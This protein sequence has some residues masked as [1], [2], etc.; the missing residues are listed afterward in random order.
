MHRLIT[1]ICVLSLSLPLLSQTSVVQHSEQR[2]GV[3]FRIPGV[4]EERMTIG[5]REFTRLSYPGNRYVIMHGAPLIPYTVE[6]VAIPPDARAAVQFQINEQEEIGP[7]DVLPAAILSGREYDE[8][9]TLNDSIY[10]ADAAFPGPIV[11]LSEPYVYRNMQVVDLRIYPVQFYALQKRVRIFKRISIQINI[12]GGGGLRGAG[13]FSKTERD[14]LQRRLL[15]FE[16]AQG[17]A[18]PQVSR[19]QRITADYDFSSGDWYRIPVSAEG[20]YR[21]TGSFLSSQGISISNVAVDQ[22]QMF[23]HGGAPLPYRSSTPVPEDLNEIAI[24]VQDNNNNGVLDPDDVIYFYG[25]GVDGWQINPGSGYRWEH[26]HHPYATRNYYLLTFNHNNGKRIPREN[27]IQ[28]ANPVAPSSFSDHFHFEEDRYNLLQSGLDWYWIRLSG[29]TD[30]ASINFTLPQNIAAEEASIRVRLKNGSSLFY[31]NQ[32]DVYIDSVNIFINNQNVGNTITIQ[33]TSTADREFVL[34]DP[35]I[36]KA[37][38]NELLIT[39]RGSETGAQTYLDFFEIKLKRPFQAENSFLKINDVLD[40]NPTEYGVANM[41]ASGNRVWDVTDFANIKEILPLQNSSTVVFQVQDSAQTAKEYYVF[42]NS[43]AKTVQQLEAIENTP[44]L[45]DP[46]RKGKLIIIVPDEFYDAAEP[47]ETLRE[48][49]L[50]DP[51]ETER[52]K[53]SEI[54]REFSSTVPDPTAIRNFLKYAY[55]NWRSS[56]TAY[57]EFVMLLGDGSYDYKNIELKNYINRVPTFQITGSQELTSRESDHYYVALTSISFDS[58]LPHLAIGR[59]PVNSIGELETFIEKL[60]NY[61]HSY[62]LNPEE[63]GWQNT[64]TFVADDEVPKNEWIHLGD[65][66]SLVSNYVPPRF[67]LKKIYLVEYP[68]QPGGFGRIKPQATEE[69]INQVNRGTLMINYFGHGNPEA[70]AHEQVFIRTR[71][72]SRIDN[73]G[74]LP[75]W[76]AATCDWA[77]FDNPSRNSMAEEMLWLKNKGGIGVVAATRPVYAGPN[78]AFVKRFYGSLFSYKSDS[79]SKITGYSMLDASLASVNDQKFR[80]FGDPSMKLADAEHKVQITSITPDT[81][82]ALSTIEVKAEVRG[83]DNSLISDF[84][85][86][87]IV[88]VFD[89]KDTVT[90]SNPVIAYYT[91]QEKGI[92]KGLISVTNGELTGKFIVPKSIKY[93]GAPNGRISI[94]AWSENRG[95]AA[96]YRDD[97]LIT[98]TESLTDNQGPEM[99][100]RF[101]G[102]EDFFDGDYVSTQPT[103]IVRL[104]DESGINLT[105][106][107]GHRIELTIDD[108][109]KKDLTDFF[110]YEKDSY[111]SGQLRYTLPALSP[112]NHTVKISAWDNVNNLAEREVNFRTIQV[113]ELALEDVVNYPNPFNDD[114]HFTFQFQSPTGFAEVTIKIYTVTGRLI[115]EIETVARPGFNKVYWDGRDRDGDILANGVYLYKII[116]DDGERKI[117][118]IEK[119]A[120]LR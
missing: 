72:L 2:I 101:E 93:D 104:T 33:N 67:D 17:W 27:S 106:E 32:N 42:N 77:R 61:A 58:L 100:V 18:V 82:K 105:Q 60:S 48:T 85:G 38:N 115:Q 80:L 109:I 76:V 97:L 56:E 12:T 54:Y 88:R 120:V 46:S 62:L 118:K 4:V 49:Q 24:D 87:A 90:V 23:N 34:N 37:G 98:G 83:I 40:G 51:I 108:R 95:A 110:V 36:L 11:E 79:T 96:G 45:R 43:V 68:I 119:L 50:P 99:E 47:L 28:Q 3:E 57:P 86:E 1:F 103:L 30:Q 55:N 8:N 116:V 26:Y 94:Y 75:L 22:I 15:N 64:L 81:L 7:I 111:Q 112:G 70:W 117:E 71:D 21:I 5:A 39:H 89:T 20:I 69:F 91:R 65:T 14:F 35:S 92:F 78:A 9:L 84:N 66:K 53:L 59:V 74:K 114:T 107:V 113:Q 10:G 31:P 52:V 16:K 44:N 6:Q 19:F 41:P 13:M 63:N 25:R 73:E 102:Q 29:F